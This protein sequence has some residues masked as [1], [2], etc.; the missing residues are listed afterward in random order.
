MKFKKIILNGLWILILLFAFGGTPALAD[1]FELKVAKLQGIF[2]SYLP[3][4]SALMI[5]VNELLQLA[6]DAHATGNDEQA[7]VYVREAGK[8]IG[9][10]ELTQESQ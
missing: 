9:Q 5:R 10:A 3:P 1:E 4:D 7:M 6:L 8:F 2:E